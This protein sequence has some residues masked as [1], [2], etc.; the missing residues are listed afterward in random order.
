M[1]SS[2]N[3]EAALGSVGPRLLDW[4][5]QSKRDLPWR[6]TC[7]PYRIWI[8]E[9]MLQQTQTA[10][11]IPYFE[12]F[13]NAFPTVWA[14]AQAPL[15]EVLRLWAGLG[16]YS[17][18]RNLHRAAQ[19]ITEKYHGQL[20]RTYNCLLELPGVGPYTAGAVV[21]IAFGERVPALD[22]NATR[23]LARLFCI[24][25]DVHAGG[26]KQRLQE[27]AQAAVPQ[28]RP[29]DYNQA[30]MELGSLICRP[31]EPLCE[32]CC[33]RDLCEAYRCG[34]QAILPRSHSRPQA[35]VVHSA[36]AIV[37][38]G[39][40]V[41]IAQRPLSGIWGGMWE[42]PNTELRE[43]ESSERTLRRFLGQ[44]FGLKVRIEGE[45]LCL[46]HGIMHRRFILTAYR[47]QVFSGRTQA[48]GHLA[49]KWV[50]PASLANY[51][52]PAP[53]RRIA[54]YLKEV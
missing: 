31:R 50:R 7:D 33:L 46:P 13:M 16:Y 11:V 18:A 4:F 48:T 51:P 6:G 2:S 10:T 9:T 5:D 34:E 24:R 17:R 41:L 40:R 25:E 15:N 38:R 45:L 36:A 52:L 53:H 12:R 1:F 49:T 32:A 8:A 23:V 28:E 30:L 44:E 47:C 21:S 54:G 14:L 37:W 27:L 22:G 3:V 43:G 20:P 39:K 29:G 19:V 35:Q 26:G 42:F